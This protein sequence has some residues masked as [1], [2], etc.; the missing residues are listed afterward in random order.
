MCIWQENIYIFLKMRI[1]S[2]VYLA[3]SKQELILQLFGR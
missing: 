1:K 3:D 2:N